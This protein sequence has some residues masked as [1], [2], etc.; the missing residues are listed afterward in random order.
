MIFHLNTEN[1]QIDQGSKFE[2]AASLVIEHNAML[3]PFVIEGKLGLENYG[4]FTC[5]TL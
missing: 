2:N 4:S 5:A 1:K 3:Y